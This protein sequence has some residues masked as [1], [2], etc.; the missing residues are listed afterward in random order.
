MCACPCCCK[1][2]RG[3]SCSLIWTTS[4]ACMVK[5]LNQDF[6]RQS[7]AQFSVASRSTLGDSPRVSLG[8]VN[9]DCIPWQGR[10]AYLSLSKPCKVVWAVALGCSLRCCGE[11]GAVM[12]SVVTWTKLERL[13]CPKR[14]PWLYQKL[15]GFQICISEWSNATVA[16]SSMKASLQRGRSGL[17]TVS[18]V[19]GFG[20]FYGDCAVLC[21][22]AER[23]AGTCTICRG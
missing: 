17:R 1:P 3:R 5:L 2:V 12:P 21:Y 20:D 4:R 23:R 9:R 10:Q 18:G 14:L 16:M 15:P 8:G 13:P 7:L 22:A 6:W 11:V 19:F